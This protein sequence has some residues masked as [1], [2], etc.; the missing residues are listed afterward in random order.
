MSFSK[1]VD[2]WILEEALRHEQARQRGDKLQTV[3]P[4][5][6]FLKFF[7]AF[8]I[9]PLIASEVMFLFDFPALP[10]PVVVL[11]MLGVLAVFY[12]RYI[13]QRRAIKA[14]QDSSTV[15]E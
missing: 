11:I 3:L 10:A 8:I 12:W 13:M 1:T 15:F 2:A 14:R 9:F 6:G 4:G 5:P 7:G